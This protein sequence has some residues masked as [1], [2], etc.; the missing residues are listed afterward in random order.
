MDVVN[1]LHLEEKSEITMVRTPNAE[2]V[3]PIEKRKS[4][5]IN[6]NAALRLSTFQFAHKHG[7]PSPIGKISIEYILNFLEKEGLTFWEECYAE[8]MQPSLPD[9]VFGILNN[10]DKNAQV[11]ALKSPFEFTSLSFQKFTFLAWEQHGFKYSEYLFEHPKKGLDTKELP[12]A[13]LLDDDDDSV[14]VF[15]STSLKSGILK[16]A[17]RHRKVTIA[18]F[19]DRDSEWHCFYYTYNSI[20]GKE[21]GDIPH[22]HYISSNWTIDRKIVLEELSK[23]HH[24]FTSSV[25]VNYRRHS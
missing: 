6:M 7:K 21:A 20:N 9:I 13:F 1:A 25:H 4:D 11:K 5:I 22:I 8:I 17:I 15:G 16:N 24:S 10:N 18:K 23:R 12:N 14:K 3:N 2:L 19:L